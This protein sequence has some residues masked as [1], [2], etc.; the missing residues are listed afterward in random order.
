MSKWKLCAWYWRFCSDD[1]ATAGTRIWIAAGVADSLRGFT[2]L[3]SMVQTELQE[4]PFSVVS[5]FLFSVDG[6]EN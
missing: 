5:V 4:N 1:R 6:D 2:G 3:S